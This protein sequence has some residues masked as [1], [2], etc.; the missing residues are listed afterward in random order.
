[1]TQ[2]YQLKTHNIHQLLA[3]MMTSLQQ[4]VHQT[5]LLAA[6]YRTRTS[7]VANC[8]QCRQHLSIQVANFSEASGMI[9]TVT[10]SIKT[11]QHHTTE[12]CKEMTT[13]MVTTQRSRTT[14]EVR[15]HIRELN[16][17]TISGMHH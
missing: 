11:I 14:G 13:E 9:Q 8:W 7:F 12:Q 6:Q 4:H 15:G 1:M 10:T 3:T 5:D 2:K 17:W 16:A